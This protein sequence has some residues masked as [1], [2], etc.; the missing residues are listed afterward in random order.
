MK[1]RILYHWAV[2]AIILT[3]CAQ[4]KPPTGGPKDEIPPEVVMSIPPNLSTNFNSKRIVIEFNEFVQLR[5]LSSQLVINPAMEER[6]DFRLKGKKLIIDLQSPLKEETTYVINF[7][8]AVV[9]LTEGNKAQN[10]QYVF[11]TGSFIDSLRFEGNVIDAFELKPVE[12]VFV[13]LYSH[14]HDTM[15]YKS[16]PDYFAKTDK[17]GNFEI[18]YI[19]EGTYMPFALKDE[20]SNYKYNPGEAIGFLDSLIVPGQPDSTNVPVQFYLFHEEDTVQYIDERKPTFYGQ[21]QM[22][23]YQPADSFSVTPINPD[24]NLLTE[25]GVVGD[26]LT[27]WFLNRADYPEI[28]SLKML[29]NA[30]PQLRDTVNWKLTRGKADEDPVMEIKD[31]L[32]FNFNPYRPMRFTFNHPVVRIDT[33]RID[34]YRDSIPVDFSWKSTESPR[35]F[36]LQ[37][38]WEQGEPYRIFAPDSTF[39]DVFGLTNDTLDKTV[40]MREDRYFGNLQFDFQYHPEDPII[41]EMLNDRGVVIEEIFP[42]KPGVLRFER[43]NP[44]TLRMRVIYDLNRNGQWDTGDFLNRIQP[45]PIENYP[46]SIQIRSNWDMEMEWDIREEDET[47]EEEEK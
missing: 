40:Q 21:Y 24:Y 9:D 2:L 36:E 12:N 22:V 29:V 8:D 41:L 1:Y 27:T 32:L 35:K 14:A 15:P 20:N 45:E 43:M 28:E 37:H 3:A 10:L 47:E 26:T 6:P 11:S 5:S 19:R 38:D 7:G 42:E 44:G 39:F 4:I 33:S 46:S 18:N 23:L 17:E 31:N 13:M 30:S 16:I 34:L 25:Q